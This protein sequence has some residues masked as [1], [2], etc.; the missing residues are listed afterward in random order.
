MLTAPLHRAS[1][2]L[3]LP[4]KTAAG[5]EFGTRARAPKDAA[6]WTRGADWL[7]ADTAPAEVRY[8]DPTQMGKVYLLPAAIDRP[9]PGLGQGEMGPDALDPALTLDVWRD[10]IRRHPG[11]LKNLLRN[12]QIDARAKKAGLDAVFAGADP[13]FLGFLLILAGIPVHVAIKWRN[14]NVIREET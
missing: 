12:P 14:R 3:A 8:K 2:G 1:P 4:A 7:I 9:V 5:L 11:E 6:P 13:V 10:R